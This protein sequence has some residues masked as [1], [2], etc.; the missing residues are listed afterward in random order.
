MSSDLQAVREGDDTVKK[1]RMSPD[2][3]MQVD[4][5][6]GSSPKATLHPLHSVCHL[7]KNGRENV[8]PQA[9]HFPSRVQPD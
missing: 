5:H 4:I 2:F 6:V 9:L 3:P 8:S 7:R 1:H